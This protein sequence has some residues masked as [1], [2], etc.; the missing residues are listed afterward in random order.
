M[1]PAAGAPHFPGYP[2][3]PSTRGVTVIRKNTINISLLILSILAIMADILT[4]TAVGATEGGAGHYLP[5][6]VATVID[7]VPTKPGWVIEPVY[8]HYKGDIQVSGGIPIAGLDAAG[9]EVTS[10]VMLLGVLYT[11]APKVFGASCTFGGYVPYVWMDVKGEVNTQLG[12]P[13]VKSREDGIGDLILIPAM[14]AW[15]KNNWQFNAAFSVFAPTGD[16]EVGRLANPGL[17]YWSFDPVIGASYNSDASGLNVALYAGVIFNS[18]NLD[19][20]YTSGSTLHLEASV[21]QLLP[22]GSGFISLGIEGFYLQQLDADSGQK[23]IFGDFKGRT[24]GIGPTLGYILPVGANTL[25]AELRWLPEMETKNR[26]NGNYTWLKIV[27]Q[28]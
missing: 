4:P 17:N 23:D 13:W 25:V 5:G 22:L 18:E 1:F 2:A 8:L 12:S 9:L 28:F 24:A 10:D 15:E 20:D 14:L 27:Y 21:Q 26:L 16:Y 7:L 11:A 3:E 19:T 6:S